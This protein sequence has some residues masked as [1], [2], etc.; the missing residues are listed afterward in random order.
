M[1]SGV[2]GRGITKLDPSAYT[3][4]STPQTRDYTLLLTLPCHSDPQSETNPPSKVVLLM[5]AANYAQS[6]YVKWSGLEF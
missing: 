2:Q 1:S 3:S 6:E 4:T 5:L